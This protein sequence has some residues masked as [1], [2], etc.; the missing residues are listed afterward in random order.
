MEILIFFFHSAFR[1]QVKD[2]VLHRDYFPN[3][4]PGDQLISEELAPEDDLI[5]EELIIYV[6]CADDEC[7]E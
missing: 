6:E 7:Q 5:E 1:L 2:T 3:A 4:M